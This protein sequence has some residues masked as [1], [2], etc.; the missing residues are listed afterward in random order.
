MCVKRTIT[1]EIAGTKFRLVA[2]ADEA[3]LA[4]LAARVNEHVERLGTSGARN[5][6]PA[7]LIAMAALSLADDLHTMESKLKQLTELTRGAVTEAISRIDQRLAAENA[8]S[9]APNDHSVQ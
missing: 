6:T 5:A 2:D 3:H 9:N 4:K 8:S 1:L 7:Q